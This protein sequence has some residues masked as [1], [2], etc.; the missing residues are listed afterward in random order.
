MRHKE[1]EN[2]NATLMYALFATVAGVAV[3]L[4]AYM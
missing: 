1:K 2:S 3:T 4:L